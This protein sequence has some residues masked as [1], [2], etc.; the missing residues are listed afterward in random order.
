MVSTHLK[1][2]SQIGNLPQIGMKIKHVWNHHLVEKLSPPQYR[3]FQKYGYP[4][5]IHFNR[6]FQYKPSILGYPYFSKHPYEGDFFNTPVSAVS[7]GRWFGPEHFHQ[8]ARHN[9]FEETRWN[10]EKTTK[11]LTKNIKTSRNTTMIKSWSIG[12]GMFSFV[13][14]S[15]RNTISGPLYSR[16]PWDL[17]FPP[18]TWD[19]MILKGK[20]TERIYRTSP[21]P[22]RLLMAHWGACGQSVGRIY[23]SH[24]KWGSPEFISRRL[25]GNP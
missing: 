17:Q 12:W 8:Q 20:K 7:N 14:S 23:W 10:F 5:I 13:N 21:R 16:E 15:G 18:V 22:P 9:K 3:C 6:V 1:N 24:W 11:R 2:I 25:H 19:P 4:Q